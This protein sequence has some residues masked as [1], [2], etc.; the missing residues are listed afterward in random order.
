VPGEAAAAA[1]AYPAQGLDEVGDDMGGRRRVAL[2]LALVGGLVTSVPSLAVAH[3][4]HDHAGDATASVT[5]PTGFSDLE[6]IGDV[7]EP[8]AVA[9]APD[10]TA[11]VAL[12]TGV[13]KS[14]DYDT[15]SDTFEPNATST[16]FADLSLTVNNYWDR[17][18]TGI[19]VDPQFGMAGHNFVYVNYAYNRD[20]RDSPPVVPKWGDPDQQ[21]DECAQ[22]AST[23]PPFAGCAAMVRVTRLTAERPAG[24]LGWTM[25]P[26]SEFELLADGCFQ[27]PSHASGD[28]VFGP[29]G[30]LYASAGDGASFDT[31]DYGQYANP[32]SGDPA[33]EGGSLRSQDYRTAA[34]PLGVDGSVVRIDPSAT[35]TPTQATA[36]QWLVAYG[37]RNPWRLA[38]RPGTNELWN[39]DVGGSNWEEINRI[40]NATT[41]P[42]TPVNRGW[43]CYEGAW[44]GSERNNAWDLLDR[45]LC[46]SLYAAGPGAVQA[47]YFSYRTRE[48]AGPLTSGEDCEFSTSSVSGV[49]FGPTTG[50]YPASYQGALFFSDFARQCI[51]RL[52][53]LPNGDPDAASISVFAQRAGTPVQ[54]VAGPGGDLY[55]VDYGIVD[56]QVTENA[57]GVHRFVYTAGNAAPTAHIAADQTS[58]PLPLTVQFDG[59]GS[60]DPDGDTLTYSWDLD[61]NGSFGDSTSTSPTKTYLSAGI[62]DVGLRVDDGH[63]HTATATV[64]VQAGNNAPQ[65][66]AVSPA[67][68]VTW[69][70]GETVH[71]SAEATDPE[72]GALAASRFTWQLSI[73]HCP[74]G[75][76]HTHPLQAYPGVKSGSFQAP[77]HE[78]PSHLLLTVTVKDSQNLAADRTIELDP[79]TVTLGFG[80]SPAGLPVTVAGR[81][82]VTSQTFIV[83]STFTI[84][85]P[86]AQQQGARRW[87]LA[88]WSDGGAATHQVVA[89][90]TARTYVA[91]YD[92]VVSSLTLQTRRDKL[93]LK[94]DGKRHTSE[95]Q[96]TLPVGTTVSVVA[97]KSQMKKD[98]RY[99]FVRWKDGGPRKRIV[100]VGEAPLVLKAIYRKAR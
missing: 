98:V 34:D 65:L 74:S 54:L 89:P 81:P 68:S 73:R 82:G 10:G 70:V 2:A 39:G 95:W 87:M 69:S 5:L 58:G 76:C 16:N 78:Y 24:S 1:S 61:G 38:F 13:I 4:G 66:G 21:Y 27:F 48:N 41:A 49:A 33:D 43:P 3:E 44:T 11:F 57:G 100:T 50:N 85:A 60:T 6:A 84:S 7:T 35:L 23:T 91:A 51:W 86:T 63:G 90:A 75:V 29:D 52:G 26:G 80:S 79:K 93:Q 9:F 64:K 77:D 22:P 12:K 42:A 36:D 31:E 99:V 62:V 94:I 96:R 30:K 28:V 45:P 18:L 37:H 53:K 14:F 92:P 97:P 32:C 17:G 25:V 46:E 67:P 55:Y 88:G 40:P 20:P 72:D 8:T 59:T 83:G 15:G 47:P 56:G 71:F 19:A